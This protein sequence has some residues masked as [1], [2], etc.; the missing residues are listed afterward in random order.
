MSLAKT[1]ESQ[2]HKQ[3][4]IH[5]AWLPVLNTFRVGTYGLMEGGVL[6]PLGHIKDD[7]G[8][9]PGALES[10]PAAGATFESEGVTT[11]RT[12]AGVEV[13]AFSQVGDSEAK[14]S[15]TF[16]RKDSVLFRAPELTLSQMP[17][18][19]L[20]ANQLQQKRQ[21]GWRRA[22]RVVSAVYHAKGPL[23]LLASEANT[24]I[25]FEGKAS[26]LKQIEAASAAV[27]FEASASSQRSFRVAG[28]AGV[29]GLGLFKLGLFGGPQH[30]AVANA[31]VE[32]G[33]DWSDVE[34]DV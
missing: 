21:V 19:Q 28:K 32:L 6:R 14:L 34:D 16:K 7:F 8:V 24:T 10:S 9:D 26:A 15:Y 12:V 22:Y 25:S 27:E 3:A 11:V 23:V 5:A 13:P 31:P 1:F 20:V 33:T 17:S 29:V 4:A 18:I 30:L 2:L